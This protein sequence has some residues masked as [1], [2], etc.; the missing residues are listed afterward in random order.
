MSQDFCKL[1]RHPKL[2]Q[3]VVAMGPSKL[4]G[5]ELEMLLM[6]VGAD[7]DK[8]YTAEHFRDA[9]AGW[10]AFGV[11]DEARAIDIVD[12]VSAA[13]ALMRGENVEP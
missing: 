3:I 2:G 6:F 8:S 4:A 11:L 12:H 13:N 9:D 10:R 1:F 7:G 5:H